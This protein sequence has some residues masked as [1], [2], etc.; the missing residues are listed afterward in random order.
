MFLTRKSLSRRTLLRGA[1]ASVAIP[2]LDSMLPAGTAL[3]QT[4]AMPQSRLASIYIPHGATMDKWTPST[5]GTD[6]E[7]TE[8]L[9]P[10]EPFRNRV[11]VVSDLAH[12]AVAPWA[13]EDTG[14]AE[15]H[16]RAAAVFLSGA[17]P[18]KGD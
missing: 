5:E 2:L 15:N 9:R 12:N 10:L 8:I 14:G 13:G 16:V 11:N 17:H 6:F 1:G 4:A 18:V 7:F 3:A